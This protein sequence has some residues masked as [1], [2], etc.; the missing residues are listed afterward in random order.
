MFPDYLDGAKVL[1]YT[2]AGHFGCI[3]DYDD[4]GNPYER[5][6]RYLAIAAYAGSSARYLFLCDQ[7]FDVIFDHCG[8]PSSD[9]K[10]KYPGAV[11]HTKNQGRSMTLPYPKEA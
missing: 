3:M 10:W 1:E 7:D 11:W 9:F 5:E 8:E 6:I 2:E 4:N